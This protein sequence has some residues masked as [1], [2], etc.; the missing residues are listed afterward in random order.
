MN[1]IAFAALA[2][3]ASLDAVEPANPAP[4]E[5][6][7]VEGRV[8]LPRDAALPTTEVTLNGDEHRALTRPDG[9]FTFHDVPPGVYLLDVLSLDYVFSQIKLNLPATA[10]EQPRCLESPR[11]HRSPLLSSVVA[12]STDH[13]RPRRGVAA[14]PPP[15]NIPAGTCT[16]ARRKNRTRTPWS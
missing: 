13:P 12:A 1:M 8:R 2:S 9:R 16:R 10:G 3:A 7:P 4:V 11:P 14:A 15:R 6:Y 5:S